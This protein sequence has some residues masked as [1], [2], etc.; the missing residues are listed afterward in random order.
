MKTIISLTLIAFAAITLTAQSKPTTEA[1]YN[2][3]FGYAVAET[4]KAFP[5]IFT[6]VTETFEG[7]KLV[8]T[9]TDIN[10]RQAPGVERKTQTLTRG[11]ETLRSYSVMTGFA[12]IRTAALTQYRGRDRKSSYAAARTD[13]GR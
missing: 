12:I 3:T 4:N 2:G 7:G 11:G 9:E 8:S 5:F 13:P 1:D 6:V 10:E